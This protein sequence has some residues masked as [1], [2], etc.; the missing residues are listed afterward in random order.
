MG[1]PTASPDIP[2]PDAKAHAPVTPGEVDD[3][4]A[5]CAGLEKTL[6]I[7]RLYPPDN[8]I[9]IDFTEDL[10]GRIHR[11]LVEYHELPLQI[12]ET[13]F[14][15]KGR[16]VH[17]DTDRAQSLPLHLYRDAIRR[18]VLYEGFDK[19]EVLDLLDVLTRR[20]DPDDLEDDLVT[21][22]WD[23]DF[24]H[25]SYF[26]LD[27]PFEG[28]PD[29]DTAQGL[30]HPTD[31][32]DDPELAAL[33]DT[34]REK[35]IAPRLSASTLSAV[36]T[37]NDAELKA[38]EKM[39][40]LENGRNLR[41]DLTTLLFEMVNLVDGEDA[42]LNLVG[43]LGQLVRAYLTAFDFQEALVVLK[44]F[45]ELEAED[46]TD[47]RRQAV[48]EEVA[49]LLERDQLKE[50]VRIFEQP[51]IK[52]VSE[53]TSFFR[54]LGPETIPALVETLPRARNTQ[55]VLSI[56]TDLG[57]ERPERLVERLS[58]RNPLVVR[59]VISALASLEDDRFSPDIIPHLQHP[60]VAVRLEAVRA[61]GRL[62]GELATKGIRRALS[63][64]EYQV[65]I[66]AIRCIE[67]MEL[68]TL[69]PVLQDMAEAKEFQERNFYE[70]QEYLRTIAKLGGE[71]VIPFLDRLIEKKG[72]FRKGLP[73]E[74]RA[75]ATAALGWIPGTVAKQRLLY[76]SRSGSRAVK[77]AAE[78]AIRRIRG[79]AI[80]ADEGDSDA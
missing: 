24:A 15:Y 32:P 44:K 16:T 2:I 50:I 11:F 35:Y 6:R 19:A 37:I 33:P 51:I 4:V 66:H 28:E 64:G 63:D 54:L 75:A 52:G 14:V 79:D 39:L 62:G 57:R 25:L 42:F 74:V 27:D 71:I 13:S 18:I 5:I 76:L 77:E 23:K 1:T 58:D 48:Q 34:K 72:L 9:Y 70:K 53:V 17:E 80:A 30:K 69:M 56:V 78:G 41:H 67:E 21:L 65:R 8:R 40:A 26:V 38:I 61:L 46:L 43:V 3:V 73:E 45:R 20:P 60:D 29:P 31:D 68:V 7:F 47:R 36:L 59:S 12:E 49:K 10:A 55:L 22:F